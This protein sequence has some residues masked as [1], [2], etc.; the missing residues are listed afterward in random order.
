MRQAP[1]STGRRT[2]ARTSSRGT[3]T[4]G[5]YRTRCPLATKPGVAAICCRRWIAQRARA[6][7]AS[8]RPRSAAPP[9]SRYLGYPDL[10]CGRTYFIAVRGAT[11]PR[12][13]RGIELETVRAKLRLLAG[14]ETPPLDNPAWSSPLEAMLAALVIEPEAGRRILAS[15]FRHESAYAVESAVALLIAI[16]APWCAAMLQEAQ[17]ATPHQGVLDDALSWL[18]LRTTSTSPDGQLSWMVSW[19]RTRIEELHELERAALRFDRVDN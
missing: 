17:E 1:G 5:R 2:S 14:L 18:G 19:S 12:I 4:G 9:T 16:A 6:W 15:S 10:A 13:T 3:T 11:T 7:S 8:E